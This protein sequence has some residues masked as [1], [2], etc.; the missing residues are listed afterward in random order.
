MPWTDVAALSAP[1]PRPEQTRNLQRAKTID[2]GGAAGALVEADDVRAVFVALNLAI[3]RVQ[4]HGRVGTGADVGVPDR[5]ARLELDAPLV[6]WRVDAHDLF[7]VGAADGQRAT[8]DVLLRQFGLILGQVS[9]GNQLGEFVV[10]IGFIVRAPRNCAQSPQRV[11]LHFPSV[12]RRSAASMS[13][14]RESF[15]PLS[16]VGLACAA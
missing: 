12:N 4:P 1:A 7:T 14:A 13:G 16:N 3:P 15:V 8:I 10:R 11:S 9:V 5:A 2:E 6:A